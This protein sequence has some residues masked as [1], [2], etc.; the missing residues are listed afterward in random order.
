MVLRLKTPG[1]SKHTFDMDEISDKQFIILKSL[2][3]HCF[4]YVATKKVFFRLYLFTCKVF[5]R[6][7][8][9]NKNTEIT[10]PVFGTSTFQGG[11]CWTRHLIV[12]T[13]PLAD[14]VHWSIFN[15]EG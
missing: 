6:V 12:R 4:Y 7:L 15:L 2:L 11:T 1:T 9:N 8:E 3:T 10:A 13:R 14:L 5:S